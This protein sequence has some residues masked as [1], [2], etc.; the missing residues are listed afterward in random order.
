MVNVLQSSLLVNFLYPMLL[1]FLITFAVLE[2]TK[3]FGEAKSQI[4]AMVG[5]VVAL[6]FAGAVF[7]TIVVSNLVQFMSVGLVVIFVGLMLWGF[8]SGNG[9]LSVS[10]G[11][12]RKIHKVF[13]FLIAGS[14]LMAVLWATGFGEAFIDGLYGLSSLIFGSSWSEGFWTNFVFVAVTA[15]VIFAAMGWNPFKGKF[16]PWIKLG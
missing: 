4:N 12:G 6:I 3:I 9:D 8:L 5:L 11:G 15:T 14:I 2:K 13:V 1:I 7:P 10:S 16:N